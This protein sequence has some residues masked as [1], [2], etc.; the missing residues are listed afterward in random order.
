MKNNHKHF[1]NSE[2]KYFPCHTLPDEGEGGFNCLFCYCPLYSMGDSCGGDF[3]FSGERKVKDCENCNLPHMP[4]YHAT[5][6]RKLKE[7]GER[8]Q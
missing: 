8:D 7:A 4:Q 5:I 2:C 1:T 6:M 3:K